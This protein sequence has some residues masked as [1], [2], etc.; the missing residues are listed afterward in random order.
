M[1]H[2][3]DKFVAISLPWRKALTDSDLLQ[4][5]DRGD[6]ASFE[7]L[8][9][10]HYDRVYGLLFRLVG[11]RAEAED[12]LQEV[13]LKLYQR[14]PTAADTNVSAWLYRVATNAGYNAVRSRRRQDERNRHL[15]PTGHS[16]AQPEQTAVQNEDK[17]R[18]R[19]ALTQLRPEQAQ[20]LLLRNLGLSYAELADSCQLN[21]NSVGKQ[22]SRAGDAFRQAYQALH[23]S[24]TTL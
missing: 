9:E 18:V 22:L 16:A 5:M 19:Q 7:A 6:T 4:R 24:E 21:P 1:I 10:R 23:S 11:T 3:K 13:F 14:P 20:L 15:V 12:L 17:A 8:F 2:V